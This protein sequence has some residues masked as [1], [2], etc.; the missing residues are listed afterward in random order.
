[1]TSDEARAFNAPFDF[2]RRKSD[3]E[4]VEYC[5]HVRE[6]VL[7]F[8]LPNEA[9]REGHS[10]LPAAARIPR[11]LDAL[12]DAQIADRLCLA[13]NIF[14]NLNIM[15]ARVHWRARLTP[16]TTEYSPSSSGD[17]FKMTR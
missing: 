4:A 15:S 16:P 14:C 13:V 17:A 9:G 7:I 8:E 3:D 2:W 6:D 12:D 1:M 10:V 5:R 11:P